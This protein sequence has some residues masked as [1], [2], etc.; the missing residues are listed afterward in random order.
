MPFI[1]AAIQLGPASPSISETATRIVNL[2]GQARDQGVV[3]ASLPELALTPY[4][5]AEVHADISRFASADENAD[6]M[7]R[8]SCAAREAGIAMTLPFAEIDRECL[9][10]SM[11]VLDSDGS[12]KGT[13]R[14]VHIPGQPEP[15]ADGAFTIMEKRYFTAGDLGFGVFDTA[16]AKLGG[17]IC[18]DRRFPESYRSL[19]VNG[20]EVICIGYNTPVSPGGP[21]LAKGRRASELAMRSGAYFTGSYIL[22]AGKAGWEGGVQYIGGSLV[23][24]P[25]GEILK[26]AKSNGDEVIAAEIDLVKVHAIR[27][28]MNH[29]ENRRPDVYVMG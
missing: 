21:G 7:E 24:A 15:K 19:Q 13:F 10:N 20:A 2:L 16:P 26:K 22:A 14:K 6:A 18:Y 3:L 12:R 11:A 28:R 4:F 8:I 17:L 9:F 5:A 1:A 29:A 25:D 23:I 27:A